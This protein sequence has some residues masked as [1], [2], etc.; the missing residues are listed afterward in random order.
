MKTH[1]SICFFSRAVCSPKLALLSLLLMLP[2]LAQA[3]YYYTTNNG[4]ITIVGYNG[5][6]GDV[7]MPSAIN[8]LPVANLGDNAFFDTTTITRVTIAN[9]ITNIG[10]YA[11]DGC[12]GLTNVTFGSSVT[13]FSSLAFLNCIS[14]TTLS[15]DPSSSTYSSMAGVLFNKNQNT[16][17]QCPPALAGTYTIP[18]SVTTI[19]TYAFFDCINLTGVTIPNG[20]SN[21]EDSAFESC[22]SLTSITIPNGVAT[23]G[24]KALSYCREL[25]SIT[26]PNSV[27]SIGLGA[28]VECDSVTNITI[29]DGVTNVMDIAF[30]NC[31]RLKGVYF[32]GNAPNI[33]P[34]EFEGATN[35]TVYYL[36]G[37]TG[38]GATYGGR[39]TAQWFL[40]N[41]VI[42]RTVPSFGVQANQFGFVISWAT[43]TSVVVEACTSLANPAWS[44][45]ATNTLNNGSSYFSDPRWTNYSGRFYRLR[46][47]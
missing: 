36:P 11:F 28:F 15:V 22:S 20:V 17:I 39:P 9:S 25:T 14:L 42:L 41:P 27:T 6:G 4:V 45:V 31:G 43:N 10:I 30:Y 34:S 47:P 24:V 12:D 8:G 40:P 26:I 13:S 7:T 32:K 44:P 38:W 5:P 16:V 35:A 46:S 2:M 37:T 18:N 23:I 1:F 21:I 3:Q 19:G 29:G 33:G